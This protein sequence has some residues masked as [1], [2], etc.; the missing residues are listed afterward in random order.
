MDIFSFF[1]NRIGDAL[2][3]NPII[4]LELILLTTAVVFLSYDLFNFKNNQVSQL[5]T[6]R[7]GK[8][9]KSFNTSKILAD[10][11]T[12]QEEKAKLLLER[13]SVQFT[14][15][16][17]MNFL[18]IGLIGGFIVGFIIFPLGFIWK[19]LFSFISSEI[20]KVFL[21][22]IIA[23]IVFAIAGSF[24]PRLWLLQ[25]ISKRKK[26]L[27][28]QIQDALMTIADS[29][30]AGHTIHAAIKIVGKEIS[31]PMG[32]EFARVA[33]EM[34][35]GR[36]LDDA[37]KDLKER[38][39]IPDFTMA[40]NAIE[41]QNE[42][43]G[44]LEDLLRNMVKIIGERQQLKREIQKTIAGSKMTGFILLAFPIFFVIAF[45]MLN[46]EAFIG[47]IESSIGI[48]LLI[49]GG[50]SY[51]LAAAIIIWIINSVSKDI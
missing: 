1:I 17:Y 15:K 2:T 8:S 48:L 6:D 24:L 22:R 47:M 26:S 51:I 7:I 12:K 23:G 45:S 28:S 37:M 50:I 46:K 14:V 16:E 11:V 35:T 30:K 29:L 9:K 21:G 5:V 20:A 33:Q 42:V 38:V 40:I 27:A 19:G 43:G 13:A 39:N 44:K 34:E 36:S 3:N 10:A 4:L 31:Y 49:V 25:L 41:I 32:P 18:Y